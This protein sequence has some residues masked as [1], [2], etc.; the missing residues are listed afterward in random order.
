[1][2][3]VLLVAVLS[4]L[5]T[6][7]LGAQSAAEESGC[8]CLPPDPTWRDYDDPDK[9]ADLI[10]TRA[11]PFLIVDVRTPD[12]Y[13]AGHIPGSASI[14]LQS[15]VRDGVSVRLDTLLIVYG[16]SGA[17]SAQAARFLE[18]QG[19]IRVIDFGSIS[20]WRLALEPG[21]PVR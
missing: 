17:R 14:P 21:A 15:L 7:M 1:M 18:E 5:A 9:L 13:R 10:L 4:V 12:E 2:R 19:Y 16:A 20:R 8:D 6:T 3:T 11:R